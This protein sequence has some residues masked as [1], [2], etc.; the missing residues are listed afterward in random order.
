[1]KDGVLHDKKDQPLQFEILLVSPSFERVMAPYVKNLKKLGVKA[2]YRTIDPALFTRRL[3]DFDFDM[4][5]NVF[6]QSQSPGNEQRNYW[7]SSSA[8]SK[9]SR[10]LIGLADPVV[11]DLTDKIIYATTQDE[12]T[13]ACKA[14]DRVLWH[15]YY[16][17]PNWYLARHR[18]AYWNRFE[19]PATLPNFYSPM[20]ALM[21][22]WLKN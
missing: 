5:V 18:V 22:W 11:D 9:G 4:V 21:T 15:G 6:G 10:N 8:T 16:V 2:S 20:Q 14:L 19:K 7:H 1:M 3:Q 12:L 17:V 13:A